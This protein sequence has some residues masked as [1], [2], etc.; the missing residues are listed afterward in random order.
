MFLFQKD[1]YIQDL[2]HIFIKLLEILKKKNLKK[3]LS[4]FSKSK[5]DDQLLKKE[6]SN[7]GPGSYNITKIDPYKN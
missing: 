6:T 7:L 4:T 1:Y 2:E 3:N 5:R